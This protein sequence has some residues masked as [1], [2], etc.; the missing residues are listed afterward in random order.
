VFV[1]SPQ[2][3]DLKIESMRNACTVLRRLPG[4][5]PKSSSFFGGSHDPQDGMTVEILEGEV[6][7]MGLRID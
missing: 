4:R 1:H 5:T 3:M 2:G 7:K 6:H